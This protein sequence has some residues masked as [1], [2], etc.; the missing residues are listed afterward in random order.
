M[1]A[2]SSAAPAPRI[3]NV[4][5]VVVFL[6]HLLMQVVNVVEA[7]PGGSEVAAALAAPPV[8]AALQYLHFAPH[9]ARLRQRL[10][11]WSLILQAITTFV[12][13]VLFGWQWGGMAG[14]LAGSFLLRLPPVAGWVM[15]GL[16]VVAVMGIATTEGLGIVS[17]AYMGVA[18]A[19]TGLILYSMARLAMLATAIHDSRGEL[20]RMAVARE[21]LRFARD[22]H[23]L[24]GYSLSSITLK[25]E[26]IHR[27]ITSN[28]QRACEEVTEVLVIS[29]QALADVREV[30][31]GYRDM[32]LLV[33]AESAGS[34]LKAAGIRAE[35]EV[36]CTGLSSIANTILATVLREGVTNVLRHSQ[37]RTCSVTAG[38]DP[39]RAGFVRLEIVNDGVGQ[40]GLV[41]SD[42]TGTGL[43]N[44]AARAAAV[45]GRLRSGVDP[46]GTTF[47]LVVSVPADAA[48]VKD[49]LALLTE[50]PRT[51]DECR[52]EPS[53]TERSALGSR[54]IA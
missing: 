41:D 44:L 43:S 53:A 6:G 37:P 38:A 14:F 2:I 9:L 15:Y 16:T 11:P 26:L 22:L 19:L 21:R 25:N 34:V 42:S 5:V 17:L 28:P 12:P 32:S 50:E 46:G 18:T 45:G 23:D 30:A 36:E 51:V 52:A 27:L 4:L 20:A 7:S 39:E 35:I 29:R 49:G 47:R 54:R 24:L 13:F 3:A 10:H 8:L 40:R 31:R 1:S 48:A 33:E